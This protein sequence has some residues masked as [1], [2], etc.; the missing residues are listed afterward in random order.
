MKKLLCVTL[1]LFAG[2]VFAADVE[3]YFPD[4]SLDQPSD[5]VSGVIETEG[6][7]LNGKEAFAK[8]AVFEKDS[9]VNNSG[10]VKVTIDP[11]MLGLGQQASHNA[12]GLYI[13]TS[14]KACKHVI[15][16]FDAK[17]GNAEGGTVTVCRL[18]GS[19]GPRKVNLTGDWE[20]QEVELSSEHPIG[21]IIFS[22]L[23]GSNNK[24]GTFYIDNINVKKAE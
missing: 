13:L 6:K 20:K 11:T 12:T 21:A 15:V 1:S 22:T 23:Y 14:N 24:G 4:G 10:C 2:A 9:G 19:C 5:N 16:T 3:N 18:W 17:W 8:I 7:L